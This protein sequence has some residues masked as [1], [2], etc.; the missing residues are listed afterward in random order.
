MASTL[1][2]SRLTYRAID[3]EKDLDWFHTALKSDIEGRILTS[4]NRLIKPDLKSESSEHLQNIRDN[5]LLG[6]IIC[7]PNEGLESTYALSPAKDIGY[8]QLTSTVPM[9]VQN[10]NTEIAIQ[11]SAGERGNGYGTEA[12]SWALDWAFRVAGLHRVA[13]GCFSFNDGARRLYARLGFTEEGRRREC[14]WWDGDWGDVV[15]FGMLG[16]EWKELREKKEME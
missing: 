16:R 12:I 10:R 5:S 7:L 6:V 13:I 11:I 14:V 2:S 9:M 4:A 15:E 1:R 8:I 3:L